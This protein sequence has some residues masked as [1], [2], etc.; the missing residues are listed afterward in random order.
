MA[1]W[2][3][4]PL[5]GP[6]V[7]PI[8]E[9]SQPYEHSSLCL[10]PYGWRL[11]WPGSGVEV[12]IL[13]A[14]YRCGY[15]FPL[16]MC[17]SADILSQSGV[18]CIATAFVMD[19]SSAYIILQRRAKRLIKESGNDKLRSKLDTGKTPGALFRLAILR[20]LKMLFLSPIVFFLSLYAASVYAYMY[21][22]FTTFPT[23]FEEQYGFSSAN[24]G[25]AYLG[26]G[27]GSLFGLVLAAALSDRTVKKL[28][29]RNGGASRPEYRLP[30]M[31]LGGFLVPAGLFWYGWTAEKKTHY[32][33][34]IIG[35]SLLGGGIVIVI[36][37]ETLVDR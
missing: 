10:R 37:S 21:L 20:P 31:V 19:E 2:I 32:I 4:G 13:A 25:L 7:G 28:T 35:T 27:V 17:L 29:T 9:F 6:V 26:I 30:L 11:S 8:S 36:V 12:D 3:I 15:S 24:S 34:P 1:G 18:I 23:I 22:C 14:V 5:I 33:V 16:T